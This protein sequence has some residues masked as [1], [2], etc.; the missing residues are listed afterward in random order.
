M[1]TAPTSKGSLLV[2]S[3]SKWPAMQERPRWHPSFACNLSG[4]AGSALDGAGRGDIGSATS[5]RE[6]AAPGMWR[7]VGTVRPFQPFPIFPQI[8]LDS[9][10]QQ[11]VRTKE[12]CRD[13]VCSPNFEW[14][15]CFNCLPT[16]Q[17]SLSNS[18]PTKLSGLTE[19]NSWHPAY[20]PCSTTSPRYSM[21]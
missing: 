15:C 4:R 2:P 6:D 12:R 5:T 18:A 17:I 8:Q 13:A 20:S 1:R 10:L 9:S 3:P 16:R 21:T 14:T 7:F 11:F 19:T